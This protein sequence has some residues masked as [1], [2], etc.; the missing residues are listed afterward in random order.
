MQFVCAALAAI[1]FFFIGIELRSRYDRSMLF[2][3]SSLLLLCGIAAIELWI[4]PQGSFGMVLP[5]VRLEHTLAIGF[6]LLLNLYLIEWRPGEKPQKLLLGLLIGGAANF[7]AMATPWLF[8]SQGNDYVTTWLYDLLFIPFMGLC[9]YG[10]LDAMLFQSRQA[11]PTQKRL[12]Q[13]HLVGFFFLILGGTLDALN[14]FLPTQSLLPAFPSYTA[15]GF[16]IFG[17]TAAGIFAE[18]FFQLLNEKHALFKRLESAYV[19]MEKANQLK[20]LG[21]STA[22]VNHEIKNYMFMISGNA[23]L[24]QEMEKLSAKGHELIHNI[25]GAVERLSRFSREILE[26]SRTKQLQ[27]KVVISLSEV[28]RRTIASHFADRREFILVRTPA[29]TRIYG[30]AEKLEQ[31]LVNLLQNAFEA[32]RPGEMP[33]IRVTLGEYPFC[34]L[35]T[36]EDHGTGCDAENLS[37]LFKAFHTTKR[38][39]GGNGLGMSLSRTLIESHGGKISA[40]SKNFGVESQH[41][42]LIHM[43]FPSLDLNFEESVL[44]KSPL[45]LFPDGVEDLEKLLRILSNALVTPYVFGSWEEWEGAGSRI[46]AMPILASANSKKISQV[47]PR[48]LKQI[49]LASTHHHQIYATSEAFFGGETLFTEEE[50]LRLTQAPSHAL[51]RKSNQV[52]LMESRKS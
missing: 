46:K 41:G 42:L 28:V 50:A 25:I 37:Q 30:D 29:D 19:D 2:F 36:I 5:I 4:Q 15:L 21:E 33:D 44:S 52:D 26:V 3:G 43:A 1:G 16:L 35:L 49:V 32:S 45:V 20:Q 18:R 47:H 51:G 9:L 8:E 48:H 38:G 24:I 11:A 34:A 6:A 13:L 39:R 22:I 14:R 17:L 7:L 27:S 40:Y 12:L 23:Q 10:V 31:V